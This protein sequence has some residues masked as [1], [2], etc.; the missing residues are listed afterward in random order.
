MAMF[1]AEIVSAEVAPGEIAGGENAQVTP[2]GNPEHERLIIPL[3]PL[4]LPALTINVEDCP[5]ITVTA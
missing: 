2:V 3:K 4:A 1:E 5:R